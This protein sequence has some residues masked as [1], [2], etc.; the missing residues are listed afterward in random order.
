MLRDATKLF[1]K[2]K[3]PD[4]LYISKTPEPAKVFSLQINYKGKKKGLPADQHI[5]TLSSEN[6]T[7]LSP[8]AKGKS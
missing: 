5:G 8:M 1:R 6:D 3:T 4:P 7:S 2:R